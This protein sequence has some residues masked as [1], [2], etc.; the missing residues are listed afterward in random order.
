MATPGSQCTQSW[1]P[2]GGGLYCCVQEAGSGRRGNMGQMQKTTFNCQLSGM[3]WTQGCAGRCPCLLLPGEKAGG[4]LRH[5][6]SL[7]S[8]V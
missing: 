6:L 7:F 5:H 1:L 3:R 4:E 2:E 8:S